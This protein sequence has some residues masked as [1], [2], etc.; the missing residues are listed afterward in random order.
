[1]AKVAA[2]TT[3]VAEPPV[4][5]FLFN[6]VRTAPLWLILRIFL[7]YQWISAAQH[8][9]ADPAWTQTGAALQG[10]WSSIVKMPPDVP[11]AAI[12]YDWYRSFIQLLL[13]AHAYTWFAKVVAFGEL[14]IGIALILGILTGFAALAGAFMNMNFMLAGSASSN[15]VLFVLAVLILMA[16][17]VAGLVG[18]DRWLLPILGTPWNNDEPKPVAAQLAPAAA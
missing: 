10:F 12:T 18:V 16:W 5:R 8:K 9:L 14:T 15:P 17:K 13:D 2:R 11:K 4:S 6:D 7:G 3:V 1:M